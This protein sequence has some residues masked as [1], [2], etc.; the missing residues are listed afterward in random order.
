MEYDVNQPKTW[1]ETV[2]FNSDG[3][4]PVIAQDYKKNTVLMFAWMNKEALQLTVESGNAIYWS[5]SRQKL[6][7]KG[8]ESGHIQIIHEIRLDCDQDVILL[9]VEQ[10]GNISCHTGRNSCFFKKLNNI[11]NNQKNN[12]DNIIYWEELNTIL[13]NPKDIY[14]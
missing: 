5:R 3:L 9:K 7:K 6:W 4:V 13:K 11:N 8:E 1:L 12:K 2:N 14:R 10:L